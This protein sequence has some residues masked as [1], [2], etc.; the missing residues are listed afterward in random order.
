MK[1]ILATAG[2]V[3]LAAAAPVS[4][5]ASTTIEGHWANPHHTVI[6]NVTRCGGAYCGTVSWSNARNREKGTTPG[7]RVLSDLHPG[8]DGTYRGS[9]FEPKRQMHGSATVRQLG[10]DVMMVKGC[11][12]LGLVCSEQ[13]WTRVS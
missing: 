6:V 10:P 1:Q 13:R 5:S 11:A 2:L 4:A 9:V 3:A 8:G 7:I 12:L